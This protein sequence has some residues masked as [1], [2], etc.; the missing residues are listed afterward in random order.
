MYKTS[1][2]TAVGKLSHYEEFIPRYIKNVTTQT[3][4]N[5]CELIVV[6]MEWHPMFESLKPYPNVKFI[7]DDQ[8]KG[9]Y[10]AWNMGIKNTTGTYITNWNVDDLRFDNNIELKVK[11]LEEDPDI[12]L[13]YNWYTVSQ[14]VHETYSNFNLSKKRLVTAYP[15]EAHKYVYQCCMC[16]PD[17]LWR[18][19]IHDK[20][21]HFDLEY[22]AIAD[23]EMW[24]RMA[25]NGFKFK[26][27]PEVLC[28][29][30]E[31]KNS[32]SNRLAE[33]RETV[34]KSKLY[35]TY[36][37]FNNPKSTDI[38]VIP[39]NESKKLSILILS[40]GRRKHYLDR[41][42]GILKPQEN[43]EV[44][45]LIN[46]DNGEKSIGT[47]RNELLK[48]A[49]GDYICFVDDDDVVSNDYIDKI[50]KATESNPDTIG[51]HLLHK[52]DNILRGLTY[53]SLKYTHWW[54]ETN[55]ENPNLK[56]YYRNPNHLNPVKREYALEVGF[57]EINHGEDRWYSQ[58]ILK[59]LKTEEYIETPIYE[60]LVRTQ[61]E[62]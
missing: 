33:S 37:G 20:I 18:S 4:F 23:W 41:L 60:Y 10:N 9:M 36:P 14:D 31:N 1:I 11:L 43:E 53:H 24:V 8:G 48:D 59:F 2:I 15:D 57:P 21:G 16:G 45:I 22:P 17:P 6:Y 56:N 46:T 7:L 44:E 39:L 3:V 5:E 28:L 26:L 25:S 38:P 13:V 51:I 52:E 34:E 42:M 40:L 35:T 50:L 19:S 27:I 61:K 47:K 54:D 29:F 49:I 12:D 62:Y 32:V 58:N 55:K 30:F